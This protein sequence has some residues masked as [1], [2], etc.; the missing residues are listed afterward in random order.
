MAVPKEKGIISFDRFRLLS[1][2]SVLQKI[3]LRFIL[4]AQKRY[5]KPYVCNILGFEPG[6]SVWDVVGIAKQL[7][8]K[9][10][11]WGL[12]LYFVSGDIKHAFDML[13]H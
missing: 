1:M 4:E 8:F 2:T 11:E 7:V 6:R 3:Y 5:C 9:A 13:R 10:L 12:P